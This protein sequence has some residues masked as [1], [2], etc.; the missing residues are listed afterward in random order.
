MRL[1]PA[2][3]L[4]LAVSLADASEWCR[5]DGGRVFVTGG[6]GFVGKWLLASLLEARQRHGFGCEIVVLSRR[7][8]EFRRHAPQIAEAP[9]VKL[10]AGDVRDFNMPEGRFDA[11]IHAATDVATSARPLDT[12]DTCVIGTRRVLEAAVRT[13]ARDMLLVSSGAVY[14]RQP[15][16]LQG[17]PEDFIGAPDSLSPR[18]G[19]GQGKRAAEWLGAVWAAEHGLRVVATRLF[20]FVGPGLPLDGSFAVGN[21]LRDALA[22]RPIV[23]QGDGTPWRS[24]LHAADMTAWLWRLFFRGGAGEAYNVGSDEA[25]TIAELARRVSDLAGSDAGIVVERQ[26]GPGVRAERYVPDI[27]KALR[28]LGLR[29]ALRLDE[30]L[31]R[32]VAWLR[33]GPRMP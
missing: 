33:D 19:Y 9:G 18:A 15:P 20:A 28:Q 1:L 24:Y 22:G 25:V 12:F 2:V 31:S 32:T 16:E 7:P 5:L 29:P 27:S 14:G 11:V 13:G 8:D 10:L 17:V 21:F 30:S 3:D 6:T 4:D 23:I 26:A